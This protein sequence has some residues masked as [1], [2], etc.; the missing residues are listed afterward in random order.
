MEWS[1][2]GIVLSSRKH[3]ETAAIVSL[4]TQSHGR[5]SGLVRGGSS[6]HARAIYQI[7]NLVTADWRARLEEHLGTFSCELVQPNAAK[8][9][10]ERLGLHALIASTSM[11]E[12]LLPERDSYPETFKNL[13]SLIT[14]L[15]T[16]DYWLPEYIYW[17]IGFLSDLGYGLDFTRCAATGVTDNL[18]FV[19]PRSG[20]AVSQKAGEPYKDKLFSLPPFLLR[21]DKTP[22]VS[23]I[24]DGFRI[25]SHFL[26]ACARETGVDNLPSA[27][28]EFIKLLAR[29]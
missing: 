28:G 20:G 27:R 1:D 6:S 19:S 2:K 24:L 18:L 21:R 10:D 25:T 7:G 26:A 9:M 13:C 12:R 29:S 22:S 5:H 8:M 16:R 3:G 4:L 14:K 15:T 17:E 11:I 23:Q